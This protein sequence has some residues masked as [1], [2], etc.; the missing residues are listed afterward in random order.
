MEGR[1]TLP[2]V[3]ALAR[4]IIA[5]QNK[6]IAQ[7]KE[8]RKAWFGSDQIPPMDGHE[9]MGH[10][11]TSAAPMDHSKM[12]H[13]TM[14]HA[15][16][17][18]MAPMSSGSDVMTM[19]GTAMGLPIT[20][21]MDM[22][23]LRDAKGSAVDHEFLQMMVPHHANAIVMAQEVLIQSKRPELQKLARQIVDDQAREIGTMEAIA[24]QKFGSL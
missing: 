23:K 16:M 17:N 20:G 6:E 21:A 19:P 5:E 22:K 14:N 10:S 2:E 12:D 1:A 9:G 4:N 24:R 11:S 13:S 18:D 3:R 8:W 7:M 15:A